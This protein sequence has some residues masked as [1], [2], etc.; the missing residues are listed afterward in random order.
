M[1]AGAVPVDLGVV[2]T[3]VTRL[4]VFG[5]VVVPEGILYMQHV[6]L[7]VALLMV[8]LNL[9]SVQVGLGCCASSTRGRTVP[10]MLCKPAANSRTGVAAYAQ[11]MCNF[12]SLWGAGV[13]YVQLFGTSIVELYLL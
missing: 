13:R 7:M 3:G 9:N 11:G 8:A 12:D 1:Q 2:V 6:G 5:A 4:L 10:T